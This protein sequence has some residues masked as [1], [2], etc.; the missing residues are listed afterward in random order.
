[1][2][3]QLADGENRDWQETEEVLLACFA[4]WFLL[5]Y[6]MTIKQV[7]Q[8]PSYLLTPDLSGQTNVFLTA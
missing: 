3:A 1:M 4:L 7:F 5:A 8:S 2:L 6:F